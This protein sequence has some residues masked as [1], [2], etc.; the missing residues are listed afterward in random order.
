MSANPTSAPGDAAQ[1]VEK[2]ATFIDTARRLL[3]DGKMIDLAGLQRNVDI[4]C[5]ALHQAPPADAA[6]LKDSVAALL[7]GL[8]ALAEALSSQYETLFQHLDGSLRRKALAAYEPD[9]R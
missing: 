5:R 4:L 8:D 1:E 3:A 7:A 9:D 2:V 6:A